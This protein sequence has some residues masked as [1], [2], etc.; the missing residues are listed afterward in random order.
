MRS[1][2]AKQIARRCMTACGIFIARNF[3]VDHADKRSRC[4]AIK[5]C[6]N[7]GDV[8]IRSQHG[9]I[10]ALVRAYCVGISRNDADCG[11]PRMVVSALAP[12]LREQQ[13]LDDNFMNN[14]DCACTLYVQTAFDPD[15]SATWT[16]T[17]WICS[18]FLR[19]TKIDTVVCDSSTRVS[20]FWPANERQ[21]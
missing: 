16:G 4:F 20:S 18:Q 8:A 5:V 13:A 14:V 19:R 10:W 1:I 17:S 6:A 12:I 2:V 7:F 3:L 9:N 15:S 21:G 11:L